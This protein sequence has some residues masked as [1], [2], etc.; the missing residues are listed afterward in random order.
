MH[1]SVHLGPERA[2]AGR[3]LPREEETIDIHVL[4]SSVVVN[5]NSIFPPVM[6]NE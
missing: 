3:L 1:K 5:V 2:A 6:I 4:I